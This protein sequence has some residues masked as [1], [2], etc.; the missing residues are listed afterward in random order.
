[1][2]VIS[3]GNLPANGDFEA[4]SLTTAPPD[5]WSYSGTWGTQADTTTDVLSGTA[6]TL[7]Q[8]TDVRRAYLGE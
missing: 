3:W 6:A 4:Q 5:T 2:I 1:M 7:A 8:N